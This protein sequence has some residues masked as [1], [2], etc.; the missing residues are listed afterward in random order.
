VFTAQ[1][2]VGADGVHSVVRE[3]AGLSVRTRD[4]HQVALVATVATQKPHANTA[5]QRFLHTGPLAF[6]P[7]FNGQSSIVW[8]LDLGAAEGLDDCDEDEFNARLDVASA[9]ALGATRVVSSRVSFPLSSVSAD[10]YIAER[11]ALIGDAAHVIHPL[12]GQGGN[13]GLL[14]A[15]ALCEAIATA[16][17]RREDP[18][19]L[20]VLR[21]YEQQRRTH[22]LAVDAV[23]SAFK[24]GFAGARGPAAWLLNR[25]L[26]TVN[27]SSVLKQ[28]FAR[29]ALGTTGE[30]PS[31][32]RAVG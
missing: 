6:L 10:S 32:A 1:L 17:P 14:D 25:A 5:W 16:P 3:G 30:L 22:N 15:A 31:L 4:Y 2:V 13:L 21:G 26:T 23:M 7:L 19:A 9:L 27:R 28:A 11:C 29:H 24:T 18:G 20:R 8:S 12:A